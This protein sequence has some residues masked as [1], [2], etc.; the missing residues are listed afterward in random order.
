MSNEYNTFTNID[1]N[2]NGNVKFIMMIDALK[3]DEEKK[4]QVVPSA[5]IKEE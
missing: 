5:K 3:K 1:E 4:E 2:A